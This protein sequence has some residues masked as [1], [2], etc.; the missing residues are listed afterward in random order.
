M[1]KHL[2][3]RRVQQICRKFNLEFYMTPF[4]TDI[5]TDYFLFKK[6]PVHKRVDL[7]FYPSG[8]IFVYFYD[9]ENRLIHDIKQVK[10]KEFYKICQYIHEYLNYMTEV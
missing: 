3:L 2:G 8:S 9:N 10:S 7:S 4:F 1:N 6:T 5:F